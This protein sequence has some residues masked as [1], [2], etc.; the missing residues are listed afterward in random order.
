[1]KFLCQFGLNPSSGSGDIVQTKSYADADD[2]DGIHTKNNM[3]PTPSERGHNCLSSHSCLN[4]RGS[5][6]FSQGVQIPRWGLTENFNMA[7][8]N[9][10]AIPG[11]GVSG[12]P[13]RPLPPPPLD[14]SMC[15]FFAITFLH[16]NV[17]WDYII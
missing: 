17:Q 16:A 2:A 15:H 9:N 8:I 12:P 5:R 6:K 10:L 14:P 1:M 3:S 4:M 13:V 7:K 11:G